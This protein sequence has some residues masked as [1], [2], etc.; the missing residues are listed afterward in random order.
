MRLFLC[1]FEGKRKLLFNENTKAMTQENFTKALEILT[2]NHA[3][4]V[5]F[6]VPVDN[7]YTN[8]YAILI[9]KSNAT[10]IRRL[11]EAGFSLSMTDKGL[12]VNK[13]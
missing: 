11:V 2:N 13:I 12:S 8:T 4:T 7:D 10:V 1:P 9:H 3:I 5:S 6:N